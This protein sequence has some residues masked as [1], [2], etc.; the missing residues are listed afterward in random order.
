MFIRITKGIDKIDRK[1]FFFDFDGTLR[2]EESNEITIKT[3][4]TFGKLKK[5]GY[6]LF[7]NTGRSFNALGSEVY[8]L[9]FD[10]FV[11]GCGTFIKYHHDIFYEAK[12]ADEDIS[13]VLKCL[14]K[15][16]VEAIF[17][18]HRGLY[19]NTIHSAYMKN[20]VDSIA[21]RGLTFLSVEDESFHFVK[22]SVHYPNKRARRGFE[23]EMADYFDF[24]LRNEDETEVVLKGYS[25]GKAMNDLL[26][27]FHIDKNDCY[28]FGDSNND[29]EMLLA[30][31][32]SIL[33]GDDAKHLVKQVDFVSK[34]AKNDGVTYALETLGLLEN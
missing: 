12:L 20:Q 8:T 33:I 10:G 17:E 5:K 25:K 1:I 2:I 29:E 11:C 16:Q 32:H 24:I 9:P 28:A 13:K 34:N 23:S 26:D 21:Q 3:Y 19:C 18:G 7:L 4:Q 31:G 15:Y 6:L 30:A 14:D 27:Y 22:M